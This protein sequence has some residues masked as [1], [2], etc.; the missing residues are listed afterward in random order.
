MTV[1]LLTEFITENSELIYVDVGMKTHLYTHI[2][3]NTVFKGTLNID[4]NS[5]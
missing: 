4:L 5:E 3:R 2:N 1:T